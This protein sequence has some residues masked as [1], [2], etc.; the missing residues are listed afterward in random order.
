MLPIRGIYEVAIKVK[1]SRDLRALLSRGSGSHRR[2][3]RRPQ[4][5][6]LL[7]RRWPVGDASVAGGSR[8]MAKAALRLRR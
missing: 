7:T 3:A 5:L 6:A 2:L 1:E 4:K 8:R